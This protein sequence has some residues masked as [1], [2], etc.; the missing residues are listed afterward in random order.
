MRTPKTA[1]EGPGARQTISPPSDSWVDPP[2]RSGQLGY[3]LSYPQCPGGAG[4]SSASFSIVGVN[5]GLA[6]TANPCLA[7]QW[8]AAGGRRSVYVNAGF[9]P[10]DAGWISA[11]CAALAAKRPGSDEMRQAYAIGCSEAVYSASVIAQAQIKVSL[12]WVDVES[13]NSWDDLNLDLNRAALQGEVDELGAGGHVVGVYAVID[14]WPGIVGQWGP[15]GVVADWVALAADQGQTADAVCKG[16]GFSG[17]PV[18][19]VQQPG[20]WPSG[21]DLDLAC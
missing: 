7:D 11:G 8:K 12:I 2:Y 18:W 21:Q 16:I 5:D 13:M 3:D 4:P 14:D 20:T 19:L 17:G 9:N 10:A 15:S 1:P 6:F